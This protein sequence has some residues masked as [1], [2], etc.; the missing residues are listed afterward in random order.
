MFNIWNDRGGLNLRVS[1]AGARPPPHGN[2]SGVA[3][4]PHCPGHIL[5]ACGYY[6]IIQIDTLC[7]CANIQYVKK[8][9]DGSAHARHNAQYTIRY[10]YMY[11]LRSKWK[12]FFFF[13]SHKRKYA[14]KRKSRIDFLNGKLSRTTAQ[15]TVESPGRNGLR[16]NTQHW[17]NWYLYIYT[18][19]LYI[20]RWAYFLVHLTFRQRIQTRR[21]R[22]IKKVCT[23]VCIHS[24]SICKWKTRLL[25]SWI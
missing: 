20:R 22:N 17:R 2:S 19:R 10:V 1:S 18:S 9:N 8:D 16:N 21:C 13:N 5:Y 15:N 25:H 7:R 6:D 14:V 11:I 4:A 24:N 23:I 3:T 12:E